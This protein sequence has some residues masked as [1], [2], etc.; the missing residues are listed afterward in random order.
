MARRFIAIFVVLSLAVFGAF[1]QIASAG[2]A[3]PGMAAHDMAGHDMGNC[4]CPPDGHH[5]SDDKSPCAPTLACMMQC[6]IV[7]LALPQTP[8]LL[9]APPAAQAVFYAEITASIPPSSSPPF[10]PPRS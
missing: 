4:V 10:R 3:M 7:P 9:L 5:P 6:G 2:E 8:A 1:P